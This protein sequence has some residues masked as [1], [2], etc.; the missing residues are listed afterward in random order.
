ENDGVANDDPCLNGRVGATATNGG[1]GHPTA[2]L[3]ALVTSFTIAGASVLLAWLNRATLHREIWYFVV[4]LADAV[5]YG[6]V[7]YLLLQRVRHAVAW[8]VALTS[9]GGAV[10]ALGMQWLTFQEAH[11]DLPQLALLSS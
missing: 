3:V 6:L 2:A 10:A 4:D 1:G 11:P 7:A 8:I 5:V 9:I